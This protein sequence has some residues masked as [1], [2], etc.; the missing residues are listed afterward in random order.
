[1]RRDIK[2]ALERIRRDMDHA[3]RDLASAS[4]TWVESTSKFVQEK[5]PKVS[6]TIDETLDKTSDTFKRTM[7][8]IDTETKTQQVKLLRAYRSFLSK[9]VDV[10]ENRL[11]R[12]KE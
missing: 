5:A 7:N 11:K 1:V 6:A 12:L 10:I 2:I 9:Q 4:K 3:R 8:T